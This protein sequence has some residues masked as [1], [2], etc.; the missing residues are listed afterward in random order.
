MITF[1]TFIDFWFSVSSYLH[2]GEFRKRAYE[3]QAVKGLRNACAH[4]NCIINDLKSGKPRYNVSYDVRIAVTGLKLH[5]V[6]VKAKLSN[7]RLQHIATTLYL[8]QYYGF[9]RGKN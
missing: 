7:E 2:D 8:S 5:D 6:N 9:N 3:L 4:N 1:G